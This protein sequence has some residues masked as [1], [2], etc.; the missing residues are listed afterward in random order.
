MFFF[1]EDKPIEQKIYSKSESKT[2]YTSPYILKIAQKQYQSSLFLGVL[3]S[4]D[5]PNHQKQK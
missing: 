4:K 3:F 1:S 2:C 5:H